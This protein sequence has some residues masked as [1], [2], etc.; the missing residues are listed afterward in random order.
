MWRGGE[1]E[2]RGLPRRPQTPEAMNKI[3]RSVGQGYLQSFTNAVIFH[4]SPVTEEGSGEFRM[5]NSPDTKE[6]WFLLWNG[7]LMLRH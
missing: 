3:G 2:E 5:I 7:T 4:T 1:C 6:R